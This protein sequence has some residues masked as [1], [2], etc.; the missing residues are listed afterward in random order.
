MIKITISKM[1]GIG[2]LLWF[3]KTYYALW[4]EWADGAHWFLDGSK[5][6]IIW[7]KPRIRFVST[8][9]LKKEG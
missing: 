5:W 2:L 1:R 3:R 7:I 9:Y 8:R 6:R 4:L